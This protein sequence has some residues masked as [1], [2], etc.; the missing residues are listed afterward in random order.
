VVVVIMVN[1]P[2]DLA[3]TSP[4]EYYKP[5]EGSLL[6]CVL[7]PADK[8]MPKAVEEI[9]EATLKQVYELFPSARYGVVG[10][11]GCLP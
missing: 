10:G 3:L 5:G 9:A 8:Y 4:A 7:T 6:Q 1:L 11:G 2:Q